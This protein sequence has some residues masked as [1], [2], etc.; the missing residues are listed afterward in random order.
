MSFK[1]KYR[2]IALNATIKFF[3]VLITLELIFVSIGFCGHSH[4]Q[5][6][7]LHH[8]RESKTTSTTTFKTNDLHSHPKTD[9]NSH[10]NNQSHC[11]SRCSCN[12][13]MIGILN[14]YALKII[15]TQNQYFHYKPQLHEFSFFP[16]IFHPPLASK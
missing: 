1:N 2:K 16:S 10:K 14:T 4:D 8:I 6:N 3:C 13:G 7:N 9:H 15:D 5:W 11:N 12:S